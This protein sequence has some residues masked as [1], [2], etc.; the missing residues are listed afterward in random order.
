LFQTR[1]KKSQSPGGK[2]KNRDVQ[3][4]P[5][6]FIAEKSKIAGATKKVAEKEWGRERR[7]K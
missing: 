1:K 7:P 6:A 5:T 2:R 4:R 3:E